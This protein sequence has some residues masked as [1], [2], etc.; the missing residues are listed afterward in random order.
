MC[1]VSLTSPAEQLETDDPAALDENSTSEANAGQRRG[2]SPASINKGP[3][4][5]TAKSRQLLSKHYRM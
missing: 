2:G 1:Q 5:L 4:D 3:P